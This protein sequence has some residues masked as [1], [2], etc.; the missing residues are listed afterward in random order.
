MATHCDWLLRNVSLATMTAGELPYGAVEGGA[1]AI[2]DGSILYAGPATGLP[3]LAPAQ[4]L[5]CQGQWLTPG[6]VDCHTHL[7]FG[8]DRAR[9]FERRLQGASYEDIARSGGG[10]LSTVR[11]TRAASE[12]ALFTSGRARLQ[13]LLAEGVT[14][15]EIKSGYGLDLET[16]LRML[17]VARQL[18][19]SLPVTVT[20]TFLGAHALPPE[21]ASGD[22]YIDYL[23]REVLPAVAAEGLADAVDV[24]CEGVGFSPEQCEQVFAAAADLGLP[25]KAH[26]EQLS[27]LGG[28][29]LAADFGA[30]SVDHLEYLDPGDVPALQRAGTVAV[31]LPG[32]FYFLGETRVPPID[33]LRE[34]GVPMAVATDLNPGSSPMASLLLALNQ[35]SVLF[36]LTP[37]E[38]LRGATCNGARALGMERKGVLAAGMDADLALWDIEHP[39]ALV[40][41]VNFH[42]PTRVWQGGRDV[43][44]GG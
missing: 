38:S 15:V 28:A 29:R 35:A 30:L 18:G 23:C 36:G 12:E 22:H 27:D 39:A 13:R 2:D 41:G 20:T 33:A 40:Y 32:A 8:G 5:D 14:S 21:Y 4:T 10:I 1:L 7:V 6:L 19:Q 26:V 3:D 24:F 17:R 11:A 37:E 31:L 34:C 42:R 43:P 9:E 16:E 25:V 44:T